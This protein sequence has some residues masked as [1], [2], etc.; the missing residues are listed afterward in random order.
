MDLSKVTA[1]GSKAV[2]FVFG[3]KL[4]E[5]PNRCNVEKMYNKN[6]R[7]G[8]ANSIIS[9]DDSGTMEVGGIGE[10]IHVIEE[11]VSGA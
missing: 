5:Q 3:A 4:I 7:K 6:E 9:Y 2:G 10:E 8:K 11:K 1:I